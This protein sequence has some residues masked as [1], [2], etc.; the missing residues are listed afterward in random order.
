MSSTYPIHI[1][2][3]YSCLPPDNVVGFYFALLNN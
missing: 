3:R 1:V 2:Y